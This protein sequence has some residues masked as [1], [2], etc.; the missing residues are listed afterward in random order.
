M[1]SELREQNREPSQQSLYMCSSDLWQGGIALEKGGLLNKW[2]R[3][4][5]ASTGQKEMKLD[6]TS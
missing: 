6:P 1:D 4:N 3:D 2:F 5:W